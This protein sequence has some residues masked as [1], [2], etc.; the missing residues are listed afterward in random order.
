MK[1][2]ELPDDIADKITRTGKELAR[3]GNLGTAW[4]IWYVTEV[5]RHVV[6][7]DRADGKERIDL[8]LVAIDD[9]CR[10]CMTLYGKG[11]ALPDD[12]DGCPK[13]MFF[14]YEEKREYASYGSCFFLTQKACQQYIDENNYHFNKPLPYAA[15]AFRNDEIQP[16]IQALILAAGEKI[17]SNHYGVIDEDTSLDI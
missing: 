2:I 8:D 12:C 1:T 17:P 9:F 10:G 6:P 5:I 13:D 14:Y 16:V 15:S 7:S 4:P 3:Q 11:E